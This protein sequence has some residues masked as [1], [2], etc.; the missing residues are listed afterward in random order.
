MV[1]CLTVARAL[2][3]AGIETDGDIV[4]V[5]TVEEEGMGSLGGMKKFLSE[6]KIDASIS[7][8]GP[9]PIGITYEATG[10]KTYEA[11]FYGIGGHAYGAFGKVANAARRSQSGR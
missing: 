7:V 1:V 4:F 3:A 9:S 2:D 8:D 6:N 5:G 11:T 10:F